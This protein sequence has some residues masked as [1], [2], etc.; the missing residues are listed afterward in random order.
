MW[1]GAKRVSSKP[2]I[3]LTKDACVMV[4]WTAKMEK[5]NIQDAVRVLE[6]TQKFSVEP[7]EANIKNHVWNQ[8]TVT[9]CNLRYFPENKF[10]RTGKATKLMLSIFDL[11]GF[12][13]NAILTLKKVDF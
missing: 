8:P 13:L 4:A 9:A 1:Y 7:T 6:R 2:H 10:R 3:V 11:K 12:N 5:M